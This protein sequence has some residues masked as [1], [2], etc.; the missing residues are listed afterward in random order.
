M[1]CYEKTFCFREALLI[2]SLGWIEL[3]SDKSRCARRVML[4]SG[5]ASPDMRNWL[6]TI[7]KHSL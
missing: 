7:C 2:S 1:E 3:V 4:L 6:S 5:G